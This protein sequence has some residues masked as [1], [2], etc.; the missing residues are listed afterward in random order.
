MDGRTSFQQCPGQAGGRSRSIVKFVVGTAAEKG[1]R[2][3]DFR[4]KASQFYFQ[5][6]GKSWAYSIID[7]VYNEVNNLKHRQAGTWTGRQVPFDT[8]MRGVRETL[9]LLEAWV[10]VKL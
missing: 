1:D 4:R 7:R 3:D 9:D 6:S 10:R 8:A 2:L 5:H